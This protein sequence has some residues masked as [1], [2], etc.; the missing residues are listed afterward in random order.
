MARTGKLPQACYH[1]ELWP[2]VTKRCNVAI[3]CEQ[4]SMELD[5]G[6]TDEILD[7]DTN[8]E[9]QEIIQ[10]KMGNEITFL[11]GANSWFGRSVKSNRKFFWK[12]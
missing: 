1:K 7:Y 12:F 11:F 5:T 10:S 9:K 3:D 8:I 4:E 6:N 2:S